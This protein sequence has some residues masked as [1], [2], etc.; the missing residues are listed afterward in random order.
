[1]ACC[2][3][4]LLIHHDGTVAACTEELAGRC[5]P[6]PAAFHARGSTQCTAELGVGGCEQCSLDRWLDGLDWEHLHWEHLVKL[7]LSARGRGLCRSHLGVQVPTATRP[8]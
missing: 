5:C 6:G 1:M 4:M 3:G 7:A 8:V 2:D